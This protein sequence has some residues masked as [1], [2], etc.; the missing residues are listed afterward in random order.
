MKKILVVGLLTSVLMLSFASIAFAFHEPGGAVHAPP[1]VTTGNINKIFDNVINALFTLLLI[2]AAILLIVAAFEFLT[3][4]GDPEQL[5]KARS[6]IIYAAVAI[7]VALLA[8]GLPA[9]FEG[10]IRTGV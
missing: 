2:G 5:G 3:G 8:K 4:G 1:L 6:K 9:L 7:V 10:L